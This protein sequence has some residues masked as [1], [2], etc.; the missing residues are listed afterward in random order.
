M[1]GTFGPPRPNWFLSAVQNLGV[2]KSKCA[3]PPSPPA[4]RIFSNG[5]YYPN[6]HIYRKQ[7]PSSLNLDVISHVFYAFAWIR[8]DGSIYFS[9]EWAD[10]QIEVDGVHGCLQACAALKKRSRV[11][12]VILS[13]GGGGQGSEPFAAV[14]HDAEKRKVFARSALDIV[15]KY[16]LDGIDIDWEHPSTPQQGFD[17]VKLLNELRMYLPRPHFVLTSALPGTEWALQYI[18][19]AEASNQLDL[20]NL[21]AYDFV[22]PWVDTCGHHAQLSTPK[23]PHNHAATIS[24]HSGVAILLSKGVPKHKILLGIPVYGRSFLGTKGVGHAFKDQGGNEGTFDYRE[25]PLPSTQEEVDEEVGAAYCVTK[26]GEFVTYDN[27]KTV[28]MKACFVKENEL[29]GLFYWT[30]TGD[31]AGSRSLVYN[32][33]VGLH[34]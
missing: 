17:Y 13:I 23:E 30:G 26:E 7:P 8:P 21:M 5:V 10:S 12:K 18:N 24:C 6:W 34:S 4:M 28:S 20:L 22:G 11:L 14:A 31:G 2:K 16:G 32:G 19:L 9:D 3:T 25:L 33:Y 29:A 15:L 27:P 1:A